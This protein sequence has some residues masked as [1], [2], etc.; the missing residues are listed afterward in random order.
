M[1]ECGLSLLR[2]NFLKHWH[3]G[4]ERTGLLQEKRRLWG[5]LITAFQNLNENQGDRC[6]PSND[7]WQEDK[8]LQHKLKQKNLRLDMRNDSQAVGWVADG[9]SMVSFPVGFPDQNGYSPEKPGLSSE[10]TPFLTG[11]WARDLYS[12]GLLVILDSAGSSPEE[13]LLNWDKFLIWF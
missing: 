1:L 13:K 11:G 6:R 2:I 7:I 3:R 12:L 4:T 10:L 9:S 5:D 8:R